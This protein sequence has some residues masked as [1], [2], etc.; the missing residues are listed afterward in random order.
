MFGYLTWRRLSPARTVFMPLELL[1]GASAEQQRQRRRTW[2]GGTDTRC[3]WPACW[4]FRGD[5]VPGLH[6]RDPDVR[7]GGPAAGDGARAAWALV[8]EENPVGRRRPERFRLAGDDADRTVRSARF[9][10]CTNRR[11]EIEAWDVEMA[12]RRLRERLAAPRRCCWR[13]SCS[14]RPAR[15]CAH[16]PPR[17]ALA[18]LP[19]RPSRRRASPR[20][21]N[22]RRKPPAMAATSKTRRKRRKSGRRA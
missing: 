1:E 3:C 7:A 16:K 5:A 10:A 13:W 20:R 4:H 19:S 11:T 8:G 14:A 17:Q 2:A 12:L 15:R 9:S 18:A 22:R 21:R 6:R